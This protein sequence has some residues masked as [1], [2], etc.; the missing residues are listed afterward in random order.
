MEIVV[1]KASV[2]A[3]ANNH[4]TLKIIHQ[5]TLLWFLLIGVRN[6]LM[7]PLPYKVVNPASDST[8]STPRPERSNK[9]CSLGNRYAPMLAADSAITPIS[10]NKARARQY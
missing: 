3:I 4:S 8:N 6:S 7:T 1:F 2:T 5:R 10:K 9:A